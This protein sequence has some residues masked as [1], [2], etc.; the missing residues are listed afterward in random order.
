MKEF[1]NELYIQKLKDT[2]MLV[3]RLHL[4]PITSL[5]FAFV[6]IAAFGAEKPQD[7]TTPAKVLATVN[8]TKITDEALMLYERR[9]GIPKDGVAEQQR[10]MMLD[11]LINRELIYQDAVNNGID[12]NPQVLAELEA[13]RK[14]LIASAML[15]Q[16]TRTVPISDD[17]LKKEYDSQTTNMTT[18]EL[19]ARHILV[20]KE[21]DAKAIIAQLDKGAKFAELATAKSTD[22]SSTNGGDLGWFKPTE[23]VEPFGK[24]VL[25]LNNGEYTKTPVKSD[26]GWHVILREDARNVP[27][28]AFEDVKEQLRMRVQNLQVE[29]YIKTLRDKAKIEPAQL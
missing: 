7:P 6:S 17:E 11:E 9:R 27:P 14:N 18:Q 19:K 16:I 24:A 8:G 13:I 22:S 5:L 2:V 1:F 20:E 4:A 26:F 21:E 29:G 28:P 23:M 12:K 10:R 25:A 3:S 15:Q